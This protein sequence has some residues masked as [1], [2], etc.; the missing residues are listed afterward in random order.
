MSEKQD[1]NNIGEQVKDA[2]TDAL[3]TGDFRQL[4]GVV[5]GTVN[6]ALGEAKRQMKMAAEEVKHAAGDITR[7]AGKTA[8]ESMNQSGFGKF[9]QAGDFIRNP[10]FKDTFHYRKSAGEQRKDTFN[11]KKNSDAMPQGVQADRYRQSAERNINIP[12]GKM[13]KIGSVAGTLFIVFGGIGTG[14][15]ALAMI[16]LFILLLVGFSL[17]VPFSLVAALLLVFV[18]MIERGCAKKERL[19]RAQRYMSLCGDKMYMD[20]DELAMHTRKSKR[21]VIKDIKKMLQMGIFPEGH[22]DEKNTCFMLDDDTYRQYLNLQ[23]D[24]RLQEEEERTARKTDKDRQAETVVEEAKDTGGQEVNEELEALMKEGQ[25]CIRRLR[26]MNDN[27]EG[28]VI[29]AKLFRL[30]NLLKEIFDRVRERPQQAPQMQKFMDYYLPTTLKLVQAYAEFDNISVPGADINS[31]KAE[32]EK[33]LDTINKAFAELL[34][35]LYRDAVFDATTDAQVLQSMLAREGLTK[36]MEQ[37]LELVG[38]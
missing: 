16:V 10:Q 19:K 35:N 9:G 37:E 34:N 23:K 5:A 38:R 20:I 8:S 1:F 24:R 17:F 7:E 13:K 12:P 33:T 26:D 25:D 14:L 18:M 2:L 6:G 32:I 28:E 30:E 22:L 3:Q 36:E 29:S 4:N 31:A 21:F 11:Y 27:I 15:A